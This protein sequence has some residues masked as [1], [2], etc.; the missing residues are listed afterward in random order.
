MKTNES[1]S[2]LSA[3][4]QKEVER[5]AVEEQRVRELRTLLGAASE[6]L[7]SRG[8]RIKELEKTLS[9]IN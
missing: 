8:S 9:K 7:Q 6:Q 4:I 1:E 2:D 5:L 3:Q